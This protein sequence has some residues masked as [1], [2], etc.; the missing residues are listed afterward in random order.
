MLTASGFQAA[1]SLPYMCE[2]VICTPPTMISCHSS[3]SSIDLDAQVPPR[4]LRW[5]FIPRCD[6]DGDIVSEVSGDGWVVIKS[7]ES[8]EVA[9]TDNDDGTDLRS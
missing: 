4:R 5:L 9:Y 1:S 3:A 8:I 7:V 2:T 6:Y